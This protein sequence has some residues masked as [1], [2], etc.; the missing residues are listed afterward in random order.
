[1]KL[2]IALPG[3]EFF[4]EVGRKMP[5]GYTFY[6]DLL[7]ISGYYRLS[8]ES[9]YSR[10]N[11]FYNKTFNCLSVYCTNNSDSVTV[12][13][14]S[15]SLL[16]WGDDDQEIL[17]QLLNLYLS[18]IR[19]EL[20]L[21]GALVSGKLSF[22]H[23]IT[24]DNFQKGLPE[25]D[26]L[27][28]AVGLGNT[29]KGARLLIENVVAK[30]LL[31]DCEEWL[32]HEGYLQNLKPCISLDDM[33][34]RISP[35]PDNKAY[36]LLYLWPPRDSQQ[37]REHASDQILEQLTE[38]S[39]LFTDEISIHYEQTLRLYKRCQNRREFTERHI[40]QRCNAENRRRIGG[41]NSANNSLE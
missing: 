34:R 20:L 6:G 15:D 18:L 7:S 2:T 12:N 14:F 16:I 11:E 31:R 8:P 22:D 32:T 17:K 26:S 36:E 35:T 9:A 10:L 39:T 27:A 37:D 4:S 28:R 38:L 29:Q 13:M 30:N 19:A 23:R 5:M 21:R 1:L 41:M 25:G 24:L 33:R 3:P 40:C